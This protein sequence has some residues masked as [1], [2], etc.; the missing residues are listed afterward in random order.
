MR[1]VVGD[2]VE[3]RRLEKVEAGGARD[4]VREPHRRP[5]TRGQHRAESVGGWQQQLEGEPERGG[6]GSGP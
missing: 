3:F 4:E 1:P 2:D 6:R 5:P